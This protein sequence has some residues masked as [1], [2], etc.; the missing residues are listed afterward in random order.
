[1]IIKK[2]TKPLA[3]QVLDA[4]IPRVSPN[5]PRLQELKKDAAIRNKGYFGERQVDYHL[6][7]LV[8][9]AVILQD[10]SLPVF[11]R[12][13]QVDTVVITN[14]AI[15]C[16]EVKNFEGKIIFNTILRQFIRDDGEKET[17][18][19]DPI[20]QVENQKIQ[21]ATWLHDQ[22]FRNIPVHF[23]IAV[24][25]PRT[26]IQVRGDEQAIAKIVAHAEHI[27]SMILAN[28]Q[29]LK[30]EGRLHF[31]ARKI[32]QTILNACQPHSVDIL[33]HYSIQESDILRGVHCPVCERLG[34]R[35]HRR[36][37]H[38]PHCKEISRNAHLKA[39]DD[40]FLLHNSWITNKKA[41]QFLGVGSRHIVTRL[42]KNSQLV[43]HPE[44]R[45]W[46]K[47]DRAADWHGVRPIER[48]L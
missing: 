31:P 29:K 25:D 5:H 45:V 42:L 24:S 35:R 39:F 20:S 47:K 17:G 11:S 15:Y 38:C 32:G 34:M 28:D 6:E 9:Q 8:R 23:F 19:R 48:R 7:R 18:F 36:N 30:A 22:G 10:V 2:R 46:T 21:L 27:P 4:L 33:R 14:Y 12:N 41:M 3:L 16:I 44:K 43:Y 1:M 26:I 40:Y 13:I 37:W